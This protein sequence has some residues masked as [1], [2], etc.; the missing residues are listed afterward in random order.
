[1]KKLPDRRVAVLARKVDTLLRTSSPSTL[2]ERTTNS[3]WRT[4]HITAMLASPSAA[5]PSSSAVVA[6]I[7]RTSG[8]SVGLR[9]L[10]QAIAS[11]TCGLRGR[12]GRRG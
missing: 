10:S 2:I 7:S 3:G 12:R 9:A 11:G 8:G 5:T 1:V 6:F 4:T